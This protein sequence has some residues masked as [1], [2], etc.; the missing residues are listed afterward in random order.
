MLQCQLKPSLTTFSSLRV[1]LDGGKMG[2]ERKWERKMGLGEVF[3]LAWMGR[4]WERKEKGR[5]KVGGSHAPFSSQVFPP[6]MGG[7]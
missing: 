2:E 4:K 3:S 1:C 7:L 5:G 6:K